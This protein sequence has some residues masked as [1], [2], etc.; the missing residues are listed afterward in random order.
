MNAEPDAFEQQ[1][2]DHYEDPYHRG[3]LEDATHAFEADNPICAD[4]IRVELRLDGDGLVEEGW[5]DGEGCVAS[6]AATSMLMEKIEGMSKKEA[7][8]FSA[9]DMLELIGPQLPPS[10]QKCCLLGWRIMQACLDSPVDDELDEFG[11]S[12]GGPSLREEC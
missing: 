4:R 8:A 11:P 12:F 6:Q 9:T 3:P 7:R 10:R 5:F 2:I 1:I